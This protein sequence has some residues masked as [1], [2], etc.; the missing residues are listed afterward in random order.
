MALVTAVREDPTDYS[1]QKSDTE[2]SKAA[3]T[4]HI[5]RLLFSVTMK[6]GTNRTNLR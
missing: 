6:N 1:G 4:K 5:L 3:Y 2:E